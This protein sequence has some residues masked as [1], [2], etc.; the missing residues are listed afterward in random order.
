MWSA[1]R[2]PFVLPVRVR[3]FEQAY[4]GNVNRD[5]RAVRLED[6]TAQAI[7]HTFGTAEDRLV[8]A[9]AEAL[10]QNNI[11]WVSV[12]VKSGNLVGVKTGQLYYV[13]KD[14]KMPSD[15]Q[16]EEQLNSILLNRLLG[17]GSVELLQHGEHDYHCARLEDW[18]RV[19]GKPLTV[20]D[21]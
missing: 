1:P 10:K 17:E 20:R 11:K 4:A 2:Q 14:I 13:I 19:L 18:E 9:L 21:S 5:P 6:T 15:T 7:E 16:S 12:P 8:Q 3:S